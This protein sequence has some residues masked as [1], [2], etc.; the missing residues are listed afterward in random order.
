M[1]VY[2][3]SW[4]A[5]IPSCSIL[6]VDYS[7]APESKFPVALQ[8]LLDVYLWILSNDQEVEDILGFHPKEIVL[9]GDSAGGNL[10]MALLHVIADLNEQLQAQNK[11]CLLKP[12]AILNLYSPYNLTL[13]ITPSMILASCDSMISAGVMLSCFEA[14]LPL[15][16]LSAV[17]AP[18][19]DDYF[20]SLH[21]KSIENV[22]DSRLSSTK[23]SLDL[24]GQDCNG[25]R[26][27][28]LDTGFWTDFLQK[29]NIYSQGVELLQSVV[30]NVKCKRK[31]LLLFLYL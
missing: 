1:Q 21:S 14:Y 8:Q 28:P 25:Q 27:D 19:S 9:A 12:K 2:I 11:P 18:Q 5:N 20:R 30:T 3:K 22:D 4:C 31:F 13:R 16:E 29:N 26:L 23:S 10:T 6:S 24:N 17:P 7:V 15:V